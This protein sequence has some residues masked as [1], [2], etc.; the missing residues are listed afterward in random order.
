[1]MLNDVKSY[2]MMLMMLNVFLEEHISNEWK[3][4]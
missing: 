1:M 3:V 2:E 4:K